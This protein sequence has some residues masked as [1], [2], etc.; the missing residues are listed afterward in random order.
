ML[1]ESVKFICEPPSFANDSWDKII[2]NVQS[3]NADVYKV[4]ETKEI[5]LAG[6]DGTYI[7]RVAN[8]STPEEC[9]GVDFSQTACGFVIEFEDVITKSQMNTNNT[10]IGGWEN[11]KMRTYVND[12]IFKALPS[13]LQN[14]IIDTKVV[15]GYGSA[16]GEG[17]SN[18]TTTDKIYLLSLH[19]IY[20]DG[21]LNKVNTFDT[22]C[23]NTRQL[24]YY[25]NKELTL[26]NG[27]DPTAI[28]KYNGTA[29]SCWLRT[30]YSG[31]FLGVNIY[32]DMFNY[33]DASDS[34]GV[35]PAFRIG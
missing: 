35:A 28:K 31:V 10:N 4:G 16:Q 23:S 33:S 11:S 29:A 17:K 15:S 1:Q 5:T 27:V 26:D 21:S 32:G 19:E 6:F 14:S 22:A 7:V 20:E 18:F 25:K 12:T 34:Y 2:A 24:D 8:N 13:E 9:S 3:G 30:A